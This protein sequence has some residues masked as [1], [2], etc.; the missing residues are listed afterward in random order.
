MKK[1]RI[2]AAAA[3]GVETICLS[4][5]TQT[6][7]D[8]WI[9]SN[10]SGEFNASL[11]PTPQA[12]VNA[13]EAAGGGTVFF[14]CGVYTGAIR[15]TTSGITLKGANRNCAILQQPSSSV[16]EL[17]IDATSSWYHGASK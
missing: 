12:A 17:T 14:P 1:L 10:T 11:Y 6:V 8:R 5:C 4:A 15:I 7:P 16:D 13:A 3:V 9:V 2:L